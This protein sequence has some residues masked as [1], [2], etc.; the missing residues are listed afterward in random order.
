MNSD[1]KIKQ[2]GENDI[3]IIEDILLDAVKNFNIWSKERVSWEEGLSREFAPGDFHIAYLNNE[4]AG[5][6]ALVDSPPFF[7]ADKEKIEKG[8]SLFL[9][10]FAVKR[11]ASGRNLSKDLMDYAVQKCRENN[12]KSLRL[13]TDPKNEKVN[14]IYLNFGFACEKIETRTIG[15]K[16]YDIVYYIYNI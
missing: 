2:A 1:I 5:C 4:P 15:G 9:R 10:R 14:Q 3:K 6:M 13:D 8:E 12:I 16:E 11:F 7:W